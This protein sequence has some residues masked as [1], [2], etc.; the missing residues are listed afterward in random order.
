MVTKIVDSD[1]N[2]V[3]KHVPDMKQ[4]L[5]Y[6]TAF[7]M[8]QMLLAGMTEPG[9]TTQNLWSY[10]LFNYKTDIGGKTGTSSN[11][12]DA[13][14]V[15][16]TPNL[17]GGA[18]VGGEYR[19]IHFRTGSLGEGSRTALPVFGYFLE[20]VLADKTLP[21]YKAKFPGPKKTISRPYMCQTPYPKATIDSTQ[22]EGVASDSVEASPSPTMVM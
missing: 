22:T 12:S 17:V 9:A 19:S 5:P 14:F 7:L 8:T 4:V 10:N 16:V 1:G 18:W 2:V 21:M 6:E 15:G 20:K 13:W 3:Y 11:H